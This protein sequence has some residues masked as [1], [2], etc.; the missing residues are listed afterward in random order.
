MNARGICHSTSFTHPHIHAIHKAKTI[1]ILQ[2]QQR[3]QQ[4]QT[5]V[6]RKSHHR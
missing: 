2:Q 1:I 3:H 6:A 5:L 4:Q